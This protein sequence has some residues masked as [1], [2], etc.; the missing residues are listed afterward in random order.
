MKIV[1]IKMQAKL[2]IEKP[3]KEEIKRISHFFVRENYGTI[4][5]T[6]E[7]KLD[8]DK[9]EIPINANYP[10]ILFNHIKKMPDKVR[11]MSFKD[12]GILE[13][14]EHG[15]VVSKPKY[16]EIVGS[17]NNKLN[18]IKNSVEKALIKVAADKFSLLSFPDH[19]FTPIQDILAWLLVEDTLKLDEF[20]MNIYDEDKKKKYLQNIKILESVKLVK[21]QNGLVLPGDP[22]IE[23]EMRKDIS[24]SQKLAA[25][26]TYFYQNGYENLD[27]ITAFLGPHLIISGQVYRESIECNQIIAIHEK[28]FKEMIAECYNDKSKLSKV[29]RYLLQLESINILKPSDK[30]DNSWEPNPEVFQK[31]IGEEELIAPIRDIIIK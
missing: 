4:P 15:E 12:L 16:H 18:E 2:P 5:S 28:G 1:L 30:F 31:L 3:K 20:L 7:P 6:G 13:L 11:F 29:P 10:R 17:I 8:G 24:N 14:S 19:M 26:L 25:A 21:N 27:T 23:I 9:W 22:L